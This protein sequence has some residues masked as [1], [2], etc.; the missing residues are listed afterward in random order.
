MPNMTLEMAREITAQ[1]HKYGAVE[2]DPKNLSEEQVF[3]YATELVKTARNAYSN[4]SHAIAVMEV[5]FAAQVEPVKSDDQLAAFY[6]ERGVE[7]P[8]VS[9]NGQPT[10]PDAPPENIEPGDGIE[11]IFPGYDDK[12]VA[13]IKQLVLSSAASGDLSP[14]EWEQIKSYE[15]AHEERKSILSLAPEFKRPEPTPSAASVAEDGQSSRDGEYSSSGDMRRAYEDGSVGTDRARQEGLPVPRPYEGDE[16]VLPV[17]ITQESDQEL[18]RLTMRFHALEARTLWLVSQEE[19]RRDAA[20]SLRSDAHRDA[21]NREFERAKSAI[22][23][24]TASAVENARS[25]ARH[26]ADGDG[27]VV[28]WRNRE[29]R[30]AIEARSLKALAEGYE[31][32]AVRL[33]R[34]QTRRERL[35][36]T[37]QGR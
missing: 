16:P 27:S 8:A 1:A 35:S 31:K 25:E 18:S 37:P 29:T 9:G 24:P 21:Y 7:V 33:S 32:A 12:K 11:H 28:S 23:K 19:G 2:E 15:S 13:E 3:S 30:H 10:A 4:D 36:A 17:D 6:H 14:E 26:A 22:E 34:E 5:L 20:A